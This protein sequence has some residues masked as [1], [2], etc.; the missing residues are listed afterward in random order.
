MQI[1]KLNSSNHQLFQDFCR[2][3]IDEYYFFFHDYEQYPDEINISLALNNDNQIQGMIGIYPTWN[4]GRFAGTVAAI[5][6]LI[7]KYGISWNEL[8]F[9]HSAKN[10][11]L[12]L[13]KETYD[14]TEH[15]RFSLKNFPLKTQPDHFKVKSLKRE[16]SKNIKLIL[17]KADPE[18]W[19]DYK[20]RFDNTHFWY[21]I[22]SNEN[23]LI[24]LVGGRIRKNG[25]CRWHTVATDPD[26]QNQ[27]YATYLLKNVITQLKPNINAL[28]VET[29]TDKLNAIKLYEN[30]GFKQIYHYHV[31]HKSQIDNHQQLN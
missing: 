24:S 25:N 8:F 13:I 17:Q 30:L 2:N 6:S 20:P 14:L 3:H 15:L 9:P 10:Q 28:F 27:G 16:D 21:G 18:G 5:T 12:L 11:F 1:Q 19:S 26:Y 31:I 4:S 29:T 7:Q 22:F 23:C